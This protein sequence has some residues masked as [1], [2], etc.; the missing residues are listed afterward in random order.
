MKAT[1]FY[2]LML[3]KFNVNVNKCVR[4]CNTINNPY[5]RVCNSNKVKNINIK[6]LT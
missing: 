3:Q 5:A 4:T 1:V 6:I 2:L